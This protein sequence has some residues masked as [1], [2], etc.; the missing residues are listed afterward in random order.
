MASPT[1]NIHTISINENSSV[2]FIQSSL[3]YANHTITPIPRV[4]ITWI[5]VFQSNLKLHALVCFGRSKKVYLTQ[6]FISSLALICLKQHNLNHRSGSHSRQY[7]TITIV[8]NMLSHLPGASS[9]PGT[10]NP[11]QCICAQN[12]VIIAPSIINFRNTPLATMSGKMAHE[13]VTITIILDQSFWYSTSHPYTRN[14]EYI[15]VN[16]VTGMNIA[17]IVNDDISRVIPMGLGVCNG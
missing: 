10:L 11:S 9:S 7:A 16:M 6:L 15:N 3:S 2:T 12:E 1:K 13:L 14:I 5:H 17:S 8:E 4:T